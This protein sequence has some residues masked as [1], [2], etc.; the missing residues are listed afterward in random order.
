[1]VHSKHLI[2]VNHNFF[3]IIIIISMCFLPLSKIP[4]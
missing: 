3:I 2:N 1:M 4:K